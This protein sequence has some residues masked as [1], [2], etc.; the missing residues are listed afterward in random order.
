MRTNLGGRDF[1]TKGP[2]TNNQ[3]SSYIKSIP[4]SIYFF[5]CKKEKLSI[6]TAELKKLSTILCILL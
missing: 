4:N 6:G 3:L 1:R 2:L 5:K